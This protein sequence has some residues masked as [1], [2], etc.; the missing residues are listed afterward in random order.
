MCTGEVFKQDMDEDSV[1]LTAAIR[2]FLAEG[3][4]W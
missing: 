4:D 1:E 2:F 3:L